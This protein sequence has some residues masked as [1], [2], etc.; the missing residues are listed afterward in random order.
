M[1]HINI[2]GD[3]WHAVPFP[4]DFHW[5]KDT[6]RPFP[7]ENNQRSLI[8]SYVGS[9][10]SYYGPARRIRGSIIHFCEQ[11]PGLCQHQV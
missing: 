5:T 9:G 7:W 8:A 1:N 11:H 2:S 4:S 10:K 6:K 3:F